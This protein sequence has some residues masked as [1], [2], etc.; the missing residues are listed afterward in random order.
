[1][2]WIDE[3]IDYT[4][5]TASAKASFGPGHL[6]LNDGVILET[7]LVECMAQTV[8]AALGARAQSAKI[9]ERKAEAASGMLAA[10]GNFRISAIPSAGKPLLIEV[11]ELKR[12]G[13]MLLVLGTVSCAGELIASG[14]LSL[15]A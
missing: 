2:Q 5:T 13:P 14:E 10:V 15:Y 7:A 6:A 4:D 12:L 8:A 9:S 1:M 11:R 3:L